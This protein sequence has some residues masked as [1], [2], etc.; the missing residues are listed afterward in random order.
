MKPRV[1]SLGPAYFFFR[2][3]TPPW[4]CLGPDHVDLGARDTR[5]NPPL[6]LGMHAPASSLAFEALFRAGVFFLS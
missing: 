4:R 1:C 6:G 5:Y 2:K 3:E